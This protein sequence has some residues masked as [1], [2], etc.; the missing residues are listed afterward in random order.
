VSHARVRADLSFAAS[1]QVSG[2]RIR[3]NENV[4]AEEVRLASCVQ[5]VLGTMRGPI[6]ASGLQLDGLAYTY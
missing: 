1:G 3:V 5:S 6:T 4:T 2:A